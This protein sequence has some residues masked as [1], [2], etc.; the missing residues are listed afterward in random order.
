V[1][2]HQQRL[3][4]LT[5]GR[6]KQ[7]SGGTERLERLF[8]SPVLVEDERAH[9]EATGIRRAAAVQRVEVL[10][11]EVALIQE[12]ADERPALEELGLAREP[13]QGAVQD[14]RR[15]ARVVVGDQHAGDAGEGTRCR[16]HIDGPLED[17]QRIGAAQLGQHLTHGGE[18]VAVFA[19]LQRLLEHGKRLVRISGEPQRS[20]QRV[21]PQLL[22]RLDRKRLRERV[23][24]IV[25]PAHRQQCLT[26]ATVRGGDIRGQ[27]HGSGEA[28]EGRPDGRRV[29]ID[30]RAG[31][32]HHP[33][34]QVRTGARRSE[35][36]ERTGV[37]QRARVVAD[38]QAD[39]RPDPEQAGVTRS[40]RL[41]LVEHVERLL[42]P[43][44]VTQDQRVHGRAPGVG[45]VECGDLVQPLERGVEPSR[46]PFELGHRR[47]D[48][49]LRRTACRGALDETL[50]SLG[51]TG[52]HGHP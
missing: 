4:S 34:L 28:V 19:E 38:R 13:L 25:R 22:V 1:H 7:R 32:E 21:E 45:P 27:L 9:L 51:L 50:G 52:L 33:E 14:P 48:T 3:G 46:S 47:E 41:E 29:D 5:T 44:A 43:S 6:G 39:L 16:L 23:D 17:R 42:C 30:R 8:G 49:H 18:D 15:G 10:Q 2:L 35:L 40:L 26:P 12:D 24:R 31:E 11:R 36:D 37:I 20:G